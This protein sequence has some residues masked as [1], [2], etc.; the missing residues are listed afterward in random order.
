MIKRG[1]HLED[2]HNLVKNKAEIEIKEM[3][4]DKM[5]PYVE[6]GEDIEYFRYMGGTLGNFEGMYNIGGSK[7]YKVDVTTTDDRVFAF[8]KKELY[9]ELLQELSNY[10]LF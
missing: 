4:K 3:V 1:K 8:S 10:S 6:R 9:K 5:R 2:A 7:S